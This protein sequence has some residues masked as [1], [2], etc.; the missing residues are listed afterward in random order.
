MEAARNFTAE[1]PKDNLCVRL[2]K[3]K[4]LC[5]I[6]LFC[7]ALVTA[8]IAVTAADLVKKTS[9][10]ADLLRVTNATVKLNGDLKD[11][12][13]NFL[14]D[15]YPEHNLTSGNDAAV[16]SSPAPV[17]LAALSRRRARD[18]LLAR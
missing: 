16:D 11:I 12:F 2:T 8:D 6:T 10:D 13:V 1:D 9:V 4:L 17:P 14:R 5:V 7:V 15:N 3:K 18:P